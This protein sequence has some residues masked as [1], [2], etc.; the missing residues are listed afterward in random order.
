MPEP[1]KAILSRVSLTAEGCS[2]DLT[3]CPIANLR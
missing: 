3:I 1:S 2:P